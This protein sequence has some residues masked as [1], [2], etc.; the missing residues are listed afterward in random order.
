MKHPFLPRRLA[1]YGTIALLLLLV[2]TAEAWINRQSRSDMAEDTARA[3]RTPSSTANAQRSPLRVD[4][5]TVLVGQQ[6]Y[7]AYCATCHGTS[8]RGDGPAAQN[9]DAPLAD[10]VTR[11]Q[12]GLL[13]D[14]DLYGRIATG[15]PDSAMPAYADQ[16]TEEQIWYLVAYLRS[17]KAPAVVAVPIPT[18]ALTATI[19]TVVPTIDLSVE[20]P[21][22]YAD[23]NEPLPPLVF[24]RSGNIW[25]SDG[26]AA[27]PL[28]RTQFAEGEYAGQPVYTPSTGRVAF[29]TVSPPPITSTSPYP[30]SALY[31]MNLDGSD[32]QVMWR[33]DNASL[34]L[35]SWT[36][37]GNALF[38]MHNGVQDDPAQSDDWR[39]QVVR[40]DLASG[41]RQVIIEDA[42]D[43]SL[44]LDGR[45]L[46]YLR[47]HDDNSTMSLMVAN[48]DGSDAREV[49][50]GDGFSSFFAPR[51]SPDGN[52]LVF[53]AIDGPATDAKGMPVAATT[54]SLVDGVVGWFQPPVAEAH[55]APWDVWRVNSDGTGLQR[56]TSFYEDLPM[57][58]F[59]PDGAE[60]VIM[61]YGGMYR[62]RPDGSELRRISPLG[63][64]GAL[65]W[66]R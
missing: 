61:G 4:T 1:V 27:D 50:P 49:V 58:V 16:L 65:D 56:L 10:L 32:Q 63:D 40:I 35:P 52:T 51:F 22:L 60:L 38:V 30:A 66:I 20:L 6:L 64:H 8:G 62:M 3:A 54:R 9:L 2:L 11:V 36:P 34:Y 41:A 45:K 53:A 12:P 13:T 5:Q 15:M 59:S 57:A 18:F 14:A 37:D 24:A 25:H 26:S 19:Q 7:R 28:Q 55:G 31:T 46:A 44:S 17:F 39:P 48:P 33:S 42:L 23:T 43:P 47:L 29:V 21:P